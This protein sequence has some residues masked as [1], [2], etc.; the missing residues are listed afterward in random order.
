MSSLYYYRVLSVISSLIC[1]SNKNFILHVDVGMEKEQCRSKE[2][3]YYDLRL[4]Y[5]RLS[6]SD[7]IAFFD[8]LS[9]AGKGVKVLFCI[10]LAICD[11]F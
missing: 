5:L 8:L 1:T 10:Q 4:S 11:H 9:V 2:M 6:F 7:V 3:K